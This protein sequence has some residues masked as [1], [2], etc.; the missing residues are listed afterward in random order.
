M[1]TQLGVGIHLNFCDGFPI[2]PPSQVRTLVREDGSFYP[3]EQIIRRLWRGQVSPAEVQRETRAQIRCIK[4]RGLTPTHADSH[5]HLHFHPFLV[6]S[7]RRALL[8]EGISCTRAAR[9]L[10]LSGNGSNGS[11]GG[12]YAGPGY[13]RVALVAYLELLQVLAFQNL[14]LPDYVLGCYTR[15]PEN[16]EI[17]FADWRSTLANLL[18][19]SYELTCHPGFPVHPEGD[20]LR[21]RREF[22]LQILTDPQ[23][24]C[25][26]ERLRIDLITYGEL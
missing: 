16:S 19:G 8:S 7:F 20:R 13:R 22:E 17:L 5:H 10:Y 1:R 23:F 15:H 26:I 18:P 3:Y 6:R 21:E 2:S 12:A 24:R 11:I 25:L 14:I 9:R 4:D